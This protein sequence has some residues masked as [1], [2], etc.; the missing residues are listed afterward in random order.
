MGKGGRKATGLGYCEARAEN[1][2]S[3]QSRTQ[4]LDGEGSLAVS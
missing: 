4:D 2:P 3:G 1:W